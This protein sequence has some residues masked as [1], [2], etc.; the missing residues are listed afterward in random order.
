MLKADKEQAPEEVAGWLS[1]LEWF[2]RRGRDGGLG[3]GGLFFFQQ[4]LTLLKCPVTLRKHPNS[5]LL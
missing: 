3:Q 5:L 2:Q 4:C 1:S